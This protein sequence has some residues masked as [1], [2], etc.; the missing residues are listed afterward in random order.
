MTPSKPIYPTPVCHD[1]GPVT[2]VLVDGYAIG[3]R[4]L[5]GV[6]FKATI[7]GSKVSVAAPAD[8]LDYLKKQGVN[9]KTWEKRIREYINDDPDSIDGAQCAKCGGDVFVDSANSVMPREGVSELVSPMDL[10]K[11]TR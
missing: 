2:E 10:F 1:C 4:L 11:V 8:T 3:D 9:A 7:K 5:E 6:M